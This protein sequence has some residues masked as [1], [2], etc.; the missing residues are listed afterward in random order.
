M[1]DSLKCIKN[2]LKVLIWPITFTVGTFLINY[3]FVSIFNSKEQGTMT[4]A[5]FIEYIS[6][7]EY[8]EKLNNYINSKS[9]LIILVTAIIFIP[10]LYRVF[11]KY[12]TK[13]DFKFKNIFIPIVFGISIWFI[14]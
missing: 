7:L 9:L 12:K 3:I 6:T 5:Q 11:K 13:N 4:N 10:V 1:K 2:I 14:S 8:Q